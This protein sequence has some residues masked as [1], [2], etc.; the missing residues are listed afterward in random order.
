LATEIW[1][2]DP[3]ITLFT[4][5]NIRAR[6]NLGRL[7][8]GETNTQ[9]YNIVLDFMKWIQ[10]QG[11]ENKLAWDSHYDANFSPDSIIYTSF[12]LKLQDYLREDI[13]FNLKLYPLEE[14]GQFHTFERG[15][16]HARLQNYLN[17]WGDRIEGA[18]TAN[19]FQPESGYMTWPQGR[20]F[21]DSYRF[22]NQT[23]GH[24]DQMFT[25][26]WL[27]WVIDIEAPSDSLDIL[28][29]ASEEGDIVSLYV[30][31]YGIESQSKN[32]NLPGFNP[33]KEATVTQLGPHSLISRNSGDN[34]DL[35][36]PVITT[37]KVR[38]KFNHEFPG[39]SF[40]VIRLK[41]K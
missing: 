10:N 37:K 20:V 4:S 38:R 28:V 30:V 21:Y 22:W 9:E 31:N 32:F 3:E 12:G 18:A 34:P 26:E 1:K 8:R 23:S 41:N 24:V 7:K 2:A 29:K 25:E 13:G 40:T 27:P 14:N 15:L 39:H 33:R 35:I 11:K 5:I 36:S 16:V 19:M 6:G 17:R